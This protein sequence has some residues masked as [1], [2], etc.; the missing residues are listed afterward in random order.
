MLD[1]VAELDL[2]RWGE[3]RCRLEQ[4]AAD[5]LLHRQARRLLW[6]VCQVLQ[7]PDAALSHLKQ[8]IAENPL[9]TRPHIAARLP[10]RSVLMLAVPGDYQANLPLDRLFDQTTLLHTLWIADPELLLRDPAASIPPDLPPVDCVFIAIG[11]D[12]RHRVA[13]RAADAL[14]AAIGR[15]TIN[16]GERI[17]RLS[18]TG[19]AAL[20]GDLTGALVPTHHPLRRGEACPI[21]FPIIIRPRG[22][23][24][25][26]NLERVDGPAGL[27][28]YF[29]R[30]PDLERFT[31]APFIDY[32]SADG[33]WRKYRV[34]FVDGVPYPLHLAIHDDWRVWY[35]NARM[36]HC[37]RKLEEERRFLAAIGSNMQAGAIEALGELGRRAELDYFGLDCGVM[38]DGRLLVFEVETGMIVQDDRSEATVRIR[39][40]V[41]RMLDARRSIAQPRP[42]PDQGPPACRHAPARHPGSEAPATAA[43]LQAASS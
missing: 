5:P 29:L 3:T 40:A 26:K 20:F 31:V 18:R 14:A 1:E 39:E 28:T 22:S 38:P 24:A 42:V 8:A 9:F 15:P 19:T 35:Y 27:Q 41:E 30:H 7:D 13:L 23:H 36:Q 33:F 43:L 32:R 2:R 12:A 17:S 10:E 16:S 4:A 6:D 25:G 11:E 21:D 34:I 37:R